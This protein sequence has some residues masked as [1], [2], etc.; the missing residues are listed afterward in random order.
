MVAQWGS[1]CHLLF[2]GL[3]FQGQSGHSPDAGATRARFL[4][5]PTLELFSQGQSFR[6]QFKPADFTRCNF[7]QLS[8]V[9]IK[10]AIQSY[11]HERNDKYIQKWLVSQQG[12]IQDWDFEPKYSI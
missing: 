5:V 7:T 6:G 12:K 2:G 1:F 3:S 9:N 11:L 8:D 4:S 10:F